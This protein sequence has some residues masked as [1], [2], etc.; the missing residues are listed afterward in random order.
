MRKLEMHAVV[1]KEGRH[2][3]AQCL[4][5]DVSSFGSTEKAALAHL[6]EAVALWYEGK[7]MPRT[8]KSKKPS[9]ASFELSCA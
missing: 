7:K 5:V 8:M 4:D 9:L 3:V 2:Y 1:W 6:Q